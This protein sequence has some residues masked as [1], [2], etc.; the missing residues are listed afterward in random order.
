M[1]ETP[2]AIGTGVATPLGHGCQRKDNKFPAGNGRSIS[3]F[4]E[5]GISENCGDRERSGLFGYLELYIAARGDGIDCRYDPGYRRF[6]VIPVIRAQH[7]QGHL[8]AYQVFVGR[9]SP[10]PP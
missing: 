2:R 1:R 4:A 3:S 7:E 5:S 10:D 6:D 8:S 9:R